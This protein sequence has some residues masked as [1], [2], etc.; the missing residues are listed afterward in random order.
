MNTHDLQ[1]THMLGLRGPQTHRRHT[2][3]SLLKCFSPQSHLT[4][5]L[6]NI[7]GSSKPP[8][9]EGIKEPQLEASLPR[10]REPFPGEAW[11]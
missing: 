4:A 5:S 11:V 7:K 10:L 9:P 1:S 6:L 3:L 8:Y 2:L